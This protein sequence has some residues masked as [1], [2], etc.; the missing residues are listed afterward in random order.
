MNDVI[1]LKKFSSDS[2]N[3]FFDLERIPLFVCLGDIS[4]NYNGWVWG[5]D[6]DIYFLK[7]CLNSSVKLPIKIYSKVLLEKIERTDS[8]EN[9]NNID[10]DKII[11]NS[12]SLNWKDLIQKLSYLSNQYVLIDFNSLDIHEIDDI[13]YLFR[14]LKIITKTNS[15]YILIYNLL[16]ESD[17][18]NIALNYGDRN[19]SL[20]LEIKNEILQPQVFNPS[21]GD[22]VFKLSINKNRYGEINKSI[23]LGKA[24]R[25]EG[26]Y[27]IKKRNIK[28]ATRLPSNRYLNMDSQDT[29]L[30]DSNGVVAYMGYFGFNLEG[31]YDY[32]KN[33]Q[34][35]TVAS[36]SFSIY[37]SENYQ[38]QDINEPII[39][40]EVNPDFMNKGE[41]F[42]FWSKSNFYVISGQR[43]FINQIQ[44]N[45]KV[46]VF[47]LTLEEFF[48]YLV[49]H[50][51]EFIGYWN[52]K[53]E[54]YLDFELSK[55][56]EQ[57]S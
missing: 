28:N 48:P 37:D 22:G 57:K 17:P 56:I 6:L 49:I 46:D 21:L 9:A 33:K 19:L 1:Q 43:R 27:V 47:L 42:T 45:K 26:Y 13:D 29:D 5:S 39:V 54:T 31:L 53:L 30:L 16:F 52:D 34:T 38:N 25:K 36:D 4:K 32:I 12:E 18:W 41:P 40:L 35:T 7:S 15:L 44:N 3:N 8:T 55:R 51:Q 20:E 11:I 10:L 14:E 23:I 24:S 50:K 2:F